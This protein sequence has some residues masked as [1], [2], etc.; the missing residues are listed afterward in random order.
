MPRGGRL[1]IRTE[2]EQIDAEFASENPE[3]TPGLFVRLSVTDTGSGI[4]PENLPHIFEPFFTTKDVGKGTGLGL[5]TVYGIVKQH[6]GWIKIGSEIGK[7]TSFDI[8]LPA[9]KHPEFIGEAPVVQTPVRGGT[10]TVLV[11]EDEDNVRQLTRIVLERHGYTVLEAPD[12]VAALAVWRENRDRIDLVLT[13]MIMPEGMSGLDLAAK[14]LIEKPQTKTIFT[15]GYSSNVF[16]HELALKHFLQK[17]YQSH[18]LARM[19][20]DCLDSG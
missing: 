16:G 2:T 8:H 9:V 3:A 6:R 1:I 15:S 5:A 10:E 18:E 11:V 13:D 17:P 14:L 7:G 4:A 12:G 20:R 19:V